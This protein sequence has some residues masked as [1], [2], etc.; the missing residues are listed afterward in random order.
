VFGDA[1]VL[2]ESLYI[3]GL[4]RDPRFRIFNRIADAGRDL[5]TD[6]QVRSR[7]NPDAAAA[8]ISELQPLA[9]YVY[10]DFRAACDELVAVL[11]KR[12]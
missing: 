12:E 2:A 11:A 3:F 8:K 4:D 6:S 7:W 5:P 10:D 9:E 1:T